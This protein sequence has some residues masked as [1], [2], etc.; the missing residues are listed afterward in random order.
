MTPQEL[1]I[2]YLGFDPTKESG[3]LKCFET[4]DDRPSRTIPNI[5]IKEVSKT[6]NLDWLKLTLEAPNHRVYLEFDPTSGCLYANLPDSS[7][8]PAIV[9]FPS[10]TLGD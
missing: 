6:D 8:C 3:R 1:L 4:E 10:G 9:V 7:D 2:N 5:R